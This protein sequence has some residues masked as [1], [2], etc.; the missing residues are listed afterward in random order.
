MKHRIFS[1]KRIKGVETAIRRA[2]EGTSGEVVVLVVPS[3]SEYVGLHALTAAFGWGAAAL[4]LLIRAERGHWTPPWQEAL[5]LPLVAALVGALVPYWGWL[6]RHLIPRRILAARVHES[7]FRGFMALGMTET[8]DR[9]GL[10]I[11]LSLLEQRVEIIADRG[12]HGAVPKG[13]W[14]E[15]VSAV[16]R[17]IQAGD[18][19]QGLEGALAAVGQ[20]L[21]ER[22]PARP[23][24]RNELQDRVHF[25][26]PKL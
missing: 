21:R 11:Y 24:D 17:G 14:D 15:Q 10:L 13:F 9:T 4:A 20:K 3:S 18:P 23:E 26:H 8:R 22:F 5:L 12:I 19:V 7:A 6:K 2:E 1:H 25:G 16:V